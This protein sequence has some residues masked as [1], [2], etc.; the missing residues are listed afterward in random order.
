MGPVTKWV[1]GIIAL[2]IFFYGIILAI[3]AIKLQKAKPKTFPCTYISGKCTVKPT[4]KNCQKVGAVPHDYC[5]AVLNGR[6]E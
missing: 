3:N 4:Y 2:V 6:I 1:N 5:E